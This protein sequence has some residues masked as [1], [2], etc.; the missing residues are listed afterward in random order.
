MLLARDGNGCNAAPQFFT[1]AQVVTLNATAGASQRPQ[2]F[3][4]NDGFAEVSVS[5]AAGPYTY[6]IMDGNSQP[7]T[8]SESTFRFEN[9]TSGTYAVQVTAANGCVANTEVTV[10]APDQIRVLNVATTSPTRCNLPDGVAEINATGGSGPLEYSLDGANFQTSNVFDFIPG[11]FYTVTVREQNNNACSITSTFTLD[12]ADGPEILSVVTVDP[13]CV[14]NNLTQTGQLIVTAIGSTPTLYYSI[15]NGVEFA[16]GT[17][18]SFTFENLSPGNYTVAVSDD[19]GCISYRGNVRLEPAAPVVVQNVTRTN[20]NCFNNRN[21]GSLTISVTGGTPPYFYSVDGGRTFSPNNV[22]ENLY[23]NNTTTGYEVV[24]R[25]DNGCTSNGGR[26]FIFNPTGLSVDQEPAVTPPTC[27]NS[28]G[29][30]FFTAN[31][32][33][34]PYNFY[35]NGNLVGTAVAP[36]FTYTNVPE[37]THTLIIEDAIGCRATAT[38]TVSSFDVNFT[39]VD[40]ACNNTENGQV[41]IR[42]SGGVG[43]FALSVEGGYRLSATPAL[44]ISSF[45]GGLTNPV[46]SLPVDYTTNDRDFTWN[47]NRTPGP[48][49]FAPGVYYISIVDE[50]TS[51]NCVVR[52]TV[53][54]K[55]S[56]AINVSS[57]FGVD[58]TCNLT[59]EDPA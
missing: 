40:A 23:P 12:Q 8:R 18:G 5:G 14:N 16:Q 11:G 28:N 48:N 58:K 9:L 36:S 52:D 3:G 7:L 15:N 59:N 24:V 26:Y 25:D 27:G 13:I 50:G 35:L 43:P 20:P 31:G 6:A 42:I 19:N 34:S 51:A 57:V 53:I 10:P 55:S 54:I 4:G 33:F 1:I 47:P 38:A 32:Q 44:T 56:G 2:C 41:Q 21:S 22:F 49:G 29:E 17:G 46:T 39:A 30:I 45:S 37:G